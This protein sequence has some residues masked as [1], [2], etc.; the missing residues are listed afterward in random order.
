MRVLFY[1]SETIKKLWNVRSKALF[2]GSLRDVLYGSRN[3]QGTDHSIRE[4]QLAV[5]NFSFFRDLKFRH[6]GP[7][8]M[9]C[10]AGKNK[11]LRK[12]LINIHYKYKCT[13]M[14]THTHKSGI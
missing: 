11:I 9:R 5:S 12:I 7:R 2:C 4:I 3:L 8:L 14:N 1:E 6:P 10:A 13:N